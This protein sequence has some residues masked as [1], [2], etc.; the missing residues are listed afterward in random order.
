MTYNIEVREKALHALRRLPI[1]AEAEGEVP[2][3]GVG[4]G[5]GRAHCD[6]FMVCGDRGRIG[7]LAGWDGCTGHTP[8]TGHYLGGAG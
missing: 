1:Q 2:L 3:D 7:G 8:A 4:S 5:R 6:G